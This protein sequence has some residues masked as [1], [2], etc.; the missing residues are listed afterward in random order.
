MWISPNFLPQA[1]YNTTKNFW[2]CKVLNMYELMLLL[3]VRQVGT[4]IPIQQ[5][6]KTELSGSPKNVGSPIQWA[7]SATR[8]R[9]NW[10]GCHCIPWGQISKPPLGREQQFSYLRKNAAAP[11]KSPWNHIH[12][13]VGEG[14]R[15]STLGSTTQEGVQDLAVDSAAAPAPPPWQISSPALPPH[16][17]ASSFPCPQIC[18]SIL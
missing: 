13:L 11:N 12:N 16:R 14:P 4:I 1:E 18:S 15:R 5:M 8:C 3:P 17:S 9:R 2:A 6:G 7:A 10:N